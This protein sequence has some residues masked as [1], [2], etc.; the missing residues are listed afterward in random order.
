MCKKSENDEKKKP[1][2]RSSFL[3]PIKANPHG[4]RGLL[5]MKRVKSL[6]TGLCGASAGS[7][8]VI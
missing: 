4:R 2:G 7:D 1:H 6:V 8:L 5:E 3:D